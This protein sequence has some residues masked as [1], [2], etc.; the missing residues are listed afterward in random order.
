MVPLYKPYIPK[1]LPELENIL[2]SGKL[3]YGK[4]GMK[5]EGKISDFLEGKKVVTTNSYN[6][7]MLVLLECI[8]I[9]PGDEIIASP[10]SCLASN[11]PFVTQGA[12]IIWADID[13]ATGTLDPDSVRSKIN[14]NVKAIFH[15][16]YCGYL[17]YIDE[18]N[19]IGKEHGIFVI[20]DA[21]EAFGSNYKGKKI[22]NLDTDFTVFSFDTVRLPNC[23][24]GGAIIF[25]N[26]DYYD[27]ALMISDYGIDRSNFR[28]ELGEINN[29]CDINLPGF[30]AKP[31]EIN[32]YIGSVQLNEINNLLDKQRLNA[33]NWIECINK[34][35]ELE[36][37]ILNPIIDTEPNYWVF[38]ALTSNKIET[39]IKLR[40]NGY[41]AS[42]VHINN[43]NYSIFKDESQ[44]SGVNKFCSQFL[45]LPS[46]WWIENCSYNAS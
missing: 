18:I 28:D 41:Y 36:I 37:K 26:D 6:S 9:K 39:I 21:I 5:F 4:W 34:K 10:M 42:G 13:P 24:N 33:S 7:A 46:G 20:D 19:S 12:K 2:H 23:I 43:N 27:K 15:N 14:P 3:S 44:L 32:S 38:G 35:S 1:K 40:N 8:G 22:G 25:N 17:G 45:A 31:N 29:E 16:H 30:G 11:Q